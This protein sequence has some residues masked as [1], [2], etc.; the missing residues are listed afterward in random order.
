MST[1]ASTIPEDILAGFTDW[2]V[3][4]L[5]RLVSTKLSKQIADVANERFS[6][7]DAKLVEYEI[8]LDKFGGKSR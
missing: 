4:V 3:S 8:L 7:R 6:A 2:E 5:H 1:E